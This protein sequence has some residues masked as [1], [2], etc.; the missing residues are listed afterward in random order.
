MLIL[1]IYNINSSIFIYI[2]W[3]T[4]AA[5]FAKRTDHAKYT[6][7]GWM[8][9]LTYG[10]TDGR[11]DGWMLEWMDGWMDGRTDGWIGG[12]MDG[13]IDGWM[14]TKILQELCHIPL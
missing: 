9:G 13:W 3:R 8:Y 14:E 4:C 2:S 12:W 1:Y 5:I 10:W 7:D 6:M 11:T